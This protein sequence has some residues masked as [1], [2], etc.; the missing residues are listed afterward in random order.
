[1]NISEC[2]QS[3]NI[4]QNIDVNHV[5]NQANSGTSIKSVSG[6]HFKFKICFKLKHKMKIY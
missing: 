5:A 1:M 4:N 3:D 6:I 2:G